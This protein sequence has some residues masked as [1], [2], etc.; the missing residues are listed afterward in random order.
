MSLC[1]FDT[2]LANELFVLAEA[3]LRGYLTATVLAATRM[4]ELVTLL[5]PIMSTGTALDN[6]RYAAA[7][8]VMGADFG[9]HRD[10]LIHLHRFLGQ[11][12][13]LNA[14]TVSLRALHSVTIVGCAV[15]KPWHV[16]CLCAS[17]PLRSKV[18]N[19]ITL[20]PAG[21]YATGEARAQLIRFTSVAQ[22]V[23]YALSTH[24]SDEP[25]PTKGCDGVYC[26]QAESTQYLPPLLVV[27]L[28]KR[29]AAGYVLPGW[30]NHT[31]VF[32]GATYDLVAVSAA[33]GAHYTARVAARPLGPADPN[34]Y[35]YDDMEA[36]GRLTQIRVRGLAGGQPPGPGPGPLA[37]SYYPRS[38]HY[39]ARSDSVDSNNRVPVDIATCRSTLTAAQLESYHHSPF[40]E[41]DDGG[42]P[43]EV[44]V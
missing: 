20:A 30:D 2:F 23:N 42:S 26:W 12:S 14:E 25:C 27:M 1:H 28:P 40:W 18:V 13:P 41:W 37:R 9:S 15:R 10:V 44:D 39:V 21:W 22:A 11:R 19:G 34:W 8:N 36:N 32:G 6:V 17:P 31:L 3:E 35:H 38:L 5:Q 29:S 16:T 24:G 4:Q 43:I 33:N 7:Q